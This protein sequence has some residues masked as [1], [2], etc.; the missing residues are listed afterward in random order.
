MDEE[1]VSGLIVW[2][3]SCINNEG[4]FSMVSR[5]MVILMRQEGLEFSKSRVNSAS[6]V[7][8]ARSSYILPPFQNKSYVPLNLWD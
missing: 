1:I 6:S 7:N 5:D 4:I 2:S 8:S 3:L